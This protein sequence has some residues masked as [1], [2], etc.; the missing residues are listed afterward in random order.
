L[1]GAQNDT[2][3][4]CHSERPHLVT[5]SEVKSLFII[6]CKNAADMPSSETGDM[7]ELTKKYRKN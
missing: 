7:K 4:I 5:L 1:G 6:T 2:F 3:R